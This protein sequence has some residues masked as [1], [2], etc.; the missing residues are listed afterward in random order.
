MT[1]FIKIL[2]IVLC[3][4][5]C[6]CKPKLN[7]A[8]AWKQL[9][10]EIDGVLYNKDTNLRVRPNAIYFDNDVPDDEKFFIQYNNVPSGVEVYKD[11]V[12]VTVPR[13]R[14]GIPSTLN[15]VRLSSDK[16][17]VLK[18]YPDSRND[19]LVSLYR[20][21]VDACGRLWAVDT[22]LL[23]VPDAR[24]QLQKPSIVVFDLKTDRL[25]LKYELKDSDLIS[26]RSPGGLTSITV[27]VTA[28]TCDDAYAYINDLATEGMVV[29]SLRKLD[30]WRIEH[31]T[32]KHDPT[33]LNF[34]V[35]GN[36]ITWR[37]GLFSISLSEP[38]QHG[39]RLAYY[40]PMVSL[41]EYTVTTDFLKTPGRTP[42]FKTLGTRGPLTQSGMHGYHAGTR[43]LFYANPAQ[44]AIL[45]WHV[46]NKMAPENVAIVVQDH[47]KLLYIS[48][49][50]VVGDDV[51][52]LVNQMTRFIFS[53]LDVSED[54]FFIHRANVKDLIRG[55]VCEH[56]G[57]DGKIV[58]QDY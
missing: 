42:T 55:T 43:T 30:S 56:R 25:L 6:A 34:T 47:K 52:V 33:A 48:D 20:P 24:T 7:T 15:Y 41:N 58:F 17:P 50:K 49:L 12:F 54:N 36:V 4:Q 44:D 1:C 27:D 23:E 45:C 31:E 10:Y 18:P 8:F 28:N 38:D 16:A 5:L 39:T 40:H 29:F 13:R 3:C 46:T 2:F 19:Q 35:G 26:E 21:R 53:T 9:S 37:D 22:G 11:R 32:F 14:F 57:D 51:W